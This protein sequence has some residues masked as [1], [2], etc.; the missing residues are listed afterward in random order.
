ML[1]L[2]RVVATH[3]ED[4]SVDLVMIED[5]TRIAGV[6]VLSSSATGN[7]GLHDLANPGRP[8]GAGQWDIAE[9]TDRD[10]IA[11]VGSVG[12]SAVVIGFLFPQVSQMLFKD[13]NRRI[14]R[15]A[16]DFYTSIDG[17]GNAELFHPSGAFVRFG[18]SAAHE[19]LTGTDSDGKWAITKNT[20]N[21]VH[22]HIEQ[23]GGKA[24]VDIAP[25]GA[26][27][28]NSQATLDF[29]IT[30]NVTAVIGGNLAATVS[31][32]TTVTSSGLCK[33]VAPTI[34]LDAVTVNC[35]NN[36]N[37]TG[38]TTTGGLVSTGLAGSGGATITGNVAITGALTNNGKSVGSTH[39]HSGVQTG[40]GTSGAPT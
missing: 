4:H 5:N 26:I 33:V 30:G 11:V 28:I 27:V 31:G 39:T 32:T 40:S 6:Q 38:I 21:Q 24:S 12:R 16:S 34:T 18:T 15:H 3:P 20:G 2:A 17:A 9:A 37:V 35:T 7:S 1:K 19:D 10:M 23:A 25:N 14:M 29:N 13:A 8:A 36:L 22:I